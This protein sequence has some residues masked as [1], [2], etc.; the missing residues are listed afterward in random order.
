MKRLAALTAMVLLTAGLASAGPIV[1]KDI[2]ADAKW[3]GHVNFDALRSM[4]LVQDLKEQCP[5]H[6]QCEAKMGE[7][8][9]KLGMNLMED[10]LGATLYSSTYGGQVGVV[11]VYVKKL[12]REKMVGLL[13]E[14]H[15]DHKTSEYGK[16]TLYSWTVGHHGKKMDLTGTFASDKLV[17]I[18]AG[19]EQVKAALDVLDGKKPGLEKDAPLIK[20]I[21]KNAL[22]ACRGID[23]PEDY[24]KTTKCPVLHVCKS[25]SVMWTEK[26]EQIT[27]KYEFVTVSEETA[28]SF[29]AI[30][31]GF[32]ALGE[33]RFSNVP[34]VTKVM[35]GLKCK[36]KG[37]S[38]TATFA[39]STDDVEAAVKAMMEQKKAHPQPKKQPGPKEKCEAEKK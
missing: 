6:K 14:K 27:G 11:L 33:L 32:K 25:A 21:P 3:F 19:A 13:K 37:E 28:K 24:R 39:M 22:M 10:V 9:K 15:P 5:F 2:S 35:D 4:K 16:R 34:A 26:N 18:G 23:V 17:V 12:D 8:A 1:S 36:V 7:L 30:V 29:K 20:G 38:F 31:E